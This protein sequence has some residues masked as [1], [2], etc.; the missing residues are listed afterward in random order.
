M[1]VDL[2][3]YSIWGVGMEDEPEIERSPVFHF[4]LCGLG[5][6][7]YISR[8]GLTPGIARILAELGRSACPAV[9][10]ALRPPSFQAAQQVLRLSQLPVAAR[11]STSPRLVD[12]IM[13]G[14]GVGCT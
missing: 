1:L 6:G 4:V 14:G 7:C 11:W 13:P 5:R 3:G 10:I 8:L 12:E 9:L 2:D